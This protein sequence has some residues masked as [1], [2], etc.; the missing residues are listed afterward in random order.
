MAALPFLKEMSIP[1]R[2]RAVHGTADDKGIYI[3]T[4]DDKFVTIDY[5]GNQGQVHDVTLDSAFE[6]SGMCTFGGLIY[7][8]VRTFTTA[9]PAV[10][11]PISKDG[12]VQPQ[13]SIPRSANIDTAAIEDLSGLEANYP[14]Y[15]VEIATGK[16]FIAYNR[17][18]TFEALLSVKDY[19]F[20]QAVETETPYASITGGVLIA[21][22]MTFADDGFYMALSNSAGIDKTIKAFNPSFNRN[23]SNDIDLSN[24]LTRVNTRALAGLGWT[25]SSLVVIDRSDVYIYGTELFPPISVTESANKQIFAL[26]GIMERFDVVRIGTDIFDVLH[27]GINAIRESSFEDVDISSQVAISTQLQNLIIIPETTLEGIGVGDFIFIHNEES[28]DEPTALPNTRWR[29]D[30]IASVGKNYRQTLYCVQ[31]LT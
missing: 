24:E 28:D 30:G 12:T 31:D 5:E 13:I 10:L 16:L 1:N 27:F 8:L 17:D 19:T 4:N 3:L 9:V 20:P 2:R 11:L 18:A 21:D 25:G 29:I 15:D 26:G 23:A 14:L 7:F 22:A 6:I